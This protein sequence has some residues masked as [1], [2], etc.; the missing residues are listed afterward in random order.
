MPDT[1]RSWGIQSLIAVLATVITAGQLAVAYY[2]YQDTKEKNALDAR[3]I[4]HDERK[5]DLDANVHIAELLLEK[6][7]LFQTQEE[8]DLGTEIATALPELGLKQKLLIQ[9]RSPQPEREK[10]EQQMVVASA[11]STLRKVTIHYEGRSD[12]GKA[13]DA[14]HALDAKGWIA[15]A[16]TQTTP[17]RQRLLYFSNQ[18]RE[19]AEALR[20]TIVTVFGKPKEW[21]PIESDDSHQN[22]YFG[23]W[24]KPT[25][26]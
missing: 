22:S 18:H 16:E 13:L 20:D 15:Y 12:S 3:K 5:D 4:L 9:S 10:R 11:L 17:T 26:S 6:R 21:L 8:R 23:V 24:L 25:G 2:T 7:D 1:N 14:V 19:D